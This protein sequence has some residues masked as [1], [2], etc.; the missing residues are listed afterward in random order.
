MHVESL[1]GTPGLAYY[2]SL[3]RHLKHGTV[4]LSRIHDTD[5]AFW[6]L[7]RSHFI[8]V[9]TVYLAMAFEHSPRCFRILYVSRTPLRP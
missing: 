6:A 5:D 4:I 8:I 1:P 3:A 7:P 9:D 2:C